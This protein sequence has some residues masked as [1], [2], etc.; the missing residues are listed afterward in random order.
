MIAAIKLRYKFKRLPVSPEELRSSI[1]QQNKPKEENPHPQELFSWNAPLRPYRKKSKGILRFYV[2]VAILITLLVYFV[3]D[4]IL[5]L[6]IWSTLFVVYILTV[7]PPA[8]IEY[9]I[10]KFG[11]EIAGTTYPWNILSSYYFIRRFDYDVLTVQGDQENN[12]FLYLVVPDTKTKDTVTKLLAEHL[13]YLKEP[14]LTTTDKM[15][16]WLTSLLPDEEESQ[17]DL[18]KT[19]A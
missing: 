19:E 15:A 1:E 8:I 18:S 16:G 12:T 10:T 9:R 11:L 2:A 3:S 13:V 4:P 6:P 5:I 14:R 7:T 17:A